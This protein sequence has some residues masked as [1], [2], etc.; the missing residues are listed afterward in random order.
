MI[1]VA[2][3]CAVKLGLHVDFTARIRLHVVTNYYRRLIGTEPS[4]LAGTL[5]LTAD[6]GS[7]QRLAECFY[8]DAG[9]TVHTTHHAG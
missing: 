5:H 2:T 8:V 1:L 6:V 3:Y 4:Y 7:R 9:H